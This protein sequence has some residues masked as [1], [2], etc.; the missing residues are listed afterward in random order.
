VADT[1]HVY[2]KGNP[3]VGKA[4]EFEF[5]QL[6]G[7]ILK[8]EKW[9]DY[10]VEFPDEKD[11]T[12]IEWELTGTFDI[13][14][15]FTAPSNAKDKLFVEGKF[16]AQVCDANA[17]Q[18]RAGSFN[19]EIAVGAAE[20]TQPG[21]DTKP[22]EEKIKALA[23]EVAALKKELADSRKVTNEMSKALK[24]YIESQHE[25]AAASGAK[26]AHGFYEDYDFA[27][28]EAKKQGKLLL[29][30]FNGEY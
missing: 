22:L 13:V 7:L 25:K 26:D 28:A 19:A 24:D 30:D 18:D 5:T 8:D 20:S 10:H 11:K 29:I 23:D 14:L 3:G 17:C 6:S 4:L 12:W 9:P 1:F 27:L 2:A 15:T 21:T 16:S